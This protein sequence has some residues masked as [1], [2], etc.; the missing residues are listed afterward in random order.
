MGRRDKELIEGVQIEG[1]AAEGKAIAKINGKVL[2]VPHAIPGDIA[3][4]QVTVKRK[5]YMEG[6]IVNMIKP[7]EL[8]IEPFCSHYTICGGCKWQPLPYQL[9]LDFKTQ[10]VVD[11]LVRIGR[12]DISEVLPAV[13]SAK[14]QF[15]RNKLEFTF[16]D[17]R[18]I[19]SKSEM[20]SIPESEKQG[21]GFHISG[22]FDKV[23]DIKKC[24]LQPEPSNRIRLFVK[25]YAL[26]NNLPFF[27]LKEQTGLLRNLIIRNTI[28]GQVM[29]IAVFAYFDES[30]IYPLL[31]S[32]ADEFKEITSLNYVINGK[33]NDSIADLPFTTYRGEDA[34]YEKMENLSFRIGPKSFFQ[35][36]SEQA[37]TLYSIVREFADLKGDEVLYDLYTGT[38]TIALFL[39]S[40][41]KKVVGIEYVPEAIEDALINAKNNGINNSSFYAGDMKLVL[42]EELIAREGV[43]D[44]M[45]LDPPRAGIHADVAKVILSASPAK[46]VYVS[47]NPATQARDI[48]LL[49]EKYS[50]TKV[51]PVDMFPH[52]HHVENVVLLVKK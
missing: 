29:V 44:V 43:P 21:L 2:F 41:C 14:Q 24:W 5:G 28:D 9:Q 27:N 12:L 51:Q 3:D 48:S 42:N 13:G 4:V 52:T 17:K 37:Y 39:A 18:W 49:S 23:L 36:N 30:I 26:R 7:S 19:E 20:E 33:R 11:Q 47:C 1:I 32:L 38:G 45:V 10:Q 8:R 50:V 25:E 40:K 22:Y 16:S 6:H 34:I 46:I 15:Y 31:D 35:T